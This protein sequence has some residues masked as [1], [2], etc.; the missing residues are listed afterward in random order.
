MNLSISETCVDR[1]LH[2]YV[3]KGQVN[4]LDVPGRYFRIIA[5]VVRRI[6]PLREVQPLSSLAEQ[7]CIILCR[8]R[9]MRGPFYTISRWGGR[10][11][12][13]WIYYPFCFR[14]EFYQQMYG[15]TLTERLHFP[16]PLAMFASWLL[17]IVVTPLMASL[18]AIP[19]YRNDSRIRETFRQSLDLLEQG[20]NIIIFPDVDYTNNGKVGDVYEG[21]FMLE[22]MY[23][24]KTGRH[25][26]FVP[27]Q[28]DTKQKSL[29]FGNPVSFTDANFNE[30]RQRV[31]DA[32]LQQW[33]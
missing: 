7:P 29:R 3:Y 30:E 12:R 25:L 14:K 16:K 32:I 23:H 22:R 31:L 13:P 27:V 6:L 19:V 33:Q 5:W 15:Y 2:R 17:S 21:F 26:P 8:H 18:G 10:Y 1:H 24:K 20:C 11:L 28:L 4:P 9:N